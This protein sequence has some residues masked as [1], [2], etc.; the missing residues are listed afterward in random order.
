MNPA[1][2]ELD[3]A[4]HQGWAGDTRFVALPVESAQ[5]ESESALEFRLRRLHLARLPGAPGAEV[6][7]AEP[8]VLAPEGEGARVLR[9]AHRAISLRRRNRQI[10]IRYRLGSVARPLQSQIPAPVQKD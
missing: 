10:L 6:Q 8:R 4:E 1:T 9:L 5:V 7:Q 2:S 3:V